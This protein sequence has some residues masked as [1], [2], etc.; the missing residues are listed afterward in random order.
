MRALIRSLYAR[1]KRG[2]RERVYVFVLCACAATCDSGIFHV[3][4]SI[5]EFICLL[6]VVEGASFFHRRI[7]FK[8]REFFLLQTYRC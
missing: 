8:S 5:E 2:G 1:R 6:N 4:P 7:A 3:L